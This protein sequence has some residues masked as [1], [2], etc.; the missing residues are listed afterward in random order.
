MVLLDILGLEIIYS[1]AI[2]GICLA[3]YLRTKDV[4]NLSHHEGLFHFRNIFFY[5]SA[6][7]IFRLVFVFLLLTYGPRPM[8][9]LNNHIIIFMLISY[10]STMAILSVVMTVAYRKILINVRN[11]NKIMHIS[12]IVLTIIVFATMSTDV[13]LIIQTLLL[14]IPVLIIVFKK[15]QSKAFQFSKQNK[16]T[17]ILLLVFWV[18]NLFSLGRGYVILYNVI[19]SIVSI[20]IFLTIY[21]R[22][23]KR[24]KN[25]KKKK[26]AGNNS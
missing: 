23:N 24:L 5:F 9:L 13:L 1:I 2:A 12:A 17:Y 19:V 25:A 11:I 4:Y 14:A 6:A 16:V 21:L 3:I 7:Y 26:Q 15:P 18:I 22:V 8:S 10:F 20:L